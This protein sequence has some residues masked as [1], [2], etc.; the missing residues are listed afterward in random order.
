MAAIWGYIELNNESAGTN[1]NP[2]EPA[3][4]GK[5]MT[6]AM[7]GYPFE[8]IDSITGSNYAFFCG[9]QYYTPESK[10]EILPFENDDLIVD[11]DAILDNRA[12]LID[13][14]FFKKMSDDSGLAID[15]NNT[16]DNISGDF[17]IITDSTIII[18][19]YRKWGHDLV[20]HLRGAYSVVIYD[21]KARKVFIFN[22]HCG[23]RCLYYC[24]MGSRFY[25]S[26]LLNPIKACLSDNEK[27]Y[28][29]E[30]FAF[31]QLFFTTEMFYDKGST[32]YKNIKMLSPGAVLSIDSKGLK[33]TDYW[34][35]VK[36]C[37][38]KR[39]H[40]NNKS[41]EELFVNTVKAAV[42]DTLRSSGDVGVTLSSGLDSSTVA[43]FAASELAIRQKKLF[44]FT[45]IPLKDFNRESDGFEV[46]D[47]SEGIK[48]ILAK[49]PN[50]VPSFVRCE[51]KSAI[52]ELERFVKM[53]E[54]PCKSNFNMVWIDEIYEKAAANDIKIMLKGQFGNSTISYG[55][56]LSTCLQLCQQFRFITAYRSLKVFKAKMHVGNRRVLH[57]IKSE[58]DERKDVKNIIKERCNITD[59]LEQRYKSIKR[60][61]RNS[62]YDGGT[63]M[64]SRKRYE[65]FVF[66]PI[67]F[68]MLGMYDTKLGLK[69]GIIVR[70]PA[71]DKRIIEL[72]LSL[73]PE[74]FVS[75]GVER[76]G[77]RGFMKGIVP[78]EIRRDI[79][80]RGLQSADLL[81][82][83]EKTLYENEQ[84]KEYAL[85]ALSDSTITAYWKKEKLDYLKN[86]I[87]DKSLEYMDVVDLVIALSLHEFMRQNL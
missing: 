78:D 7:D 44:S 42:T 81:F 23:N 64:D 21:K 60:T 47:E 22:D 63:V 65:R 69:R 33:K 30:W 36:L 18:E 32:P 28:N 87:I 58:F 38:H 35:P 3:S 71:K 61:L 68:Q 84:Y 53:I 16:P 25:F 10:M 39:K 34:N 19:S 26:T 17:S 43:S 51:G 85:S 13:E 29:D 73:S 83:I 49:Y 12:E 15:S 52:T 79:N 72:C 45:S 14:L 76:F 37:R 48:P 86:K 41:T 62:K 2:E 6:A 70:D 24:L 9:H 67:V 20:N 50:I 1:S 8:R 74:C 5:K 80:H 75:G 40:R 57:V 46:F 11:A 82:R 77:I 55:A 31:C 56:I 4:C 66:S 54:M 27:I 59:E